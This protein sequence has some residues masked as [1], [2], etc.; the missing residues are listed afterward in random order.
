MLYFQNRH[1]L[2]LLSEILQFFLK[3][4]QKDG[5]NAVKDQIV[6]CRK[7]QRPDHAC[8]SLIALQER[9]SC[10]DD[11]LKRDDTGKRGIFHQCYDLVGHGR[12]DPLD[13]LK[14]RDLKEDLALRHAEHESCLLLSLRNSLDPSPVNLR[15]VAGVVEDKGN[16]SCEETSAL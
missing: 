8:D 4:S 6:H 2:R 15:K 13:H 14:E 16:G 10:P 11:L 3:T 9:L 7:E 1:M 5:Q 12:H